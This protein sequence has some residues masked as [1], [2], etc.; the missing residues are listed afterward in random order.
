MDCMVRL[1]KRKHGDRSLCPLCPEKWFDNEEDEDEV[2]GVKEVLA[3]LRNG[4]VSHVGWTEL[5]VELLATELLRCVQTVAYAAVRFGNAFAITGDAYAIVEGMMAVVKT[6]DKQTR[7]LDVVC[8]Q[9]HIRAFSGMRSNGDSRAY[10]DEMSS[11]ACDIAADAVALYAHTH[12]LLAIIDRASCIPDT[13]NFE[14]SDLRAVAEQ[15][16]VAAGAFLSEYDLFEYEKGMLESQRLEQEGLEERFQEEEAE[17]AKREAAVTAREEA[18]TEREKKVALRE[19]GVGAQHI[20]MPDPVGAVT[21][22]DSDEDGEPMPKV[23]AKA[24][25]VQLKPGSKRKADIAQLKKDSEQM[26]KKMKTLGQTQGAEVP[27]GMGSP[28]SGGMED[29]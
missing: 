17:L 3:L 29:V 13:A 12:R 20:P 22:S 4:E 1:M 8:Q 9:L 28:E 2:A 25:P 21:E 7:C 6:M 18:V 23:D 19:H 14:M 15:L 10:T 11:F 5:K 27:E 24:M 26:A 16:Q